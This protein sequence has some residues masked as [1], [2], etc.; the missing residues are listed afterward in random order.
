[1]SSNPSPIE[2][3][4]GPR[5]LELLSAMPA[6]AD[7]T[8][9][10]LLF[11]HGLGH[12][13]WCWEHW[14]RESATRGYAGYAVSLRGHGG[15]AG[16]LRTAR[17]SH[18]VKDVI[19]TAASLPRRP[20]LVGH[21][22]GGLVVQQALARYAAHAGVLVAPVPAHPAVGSLASIA[23]QHPLDAVRMTLGGSLPLRPRYL[24]AGLDPSEAQQQAHRCGPESPFAQYQLL[25]H[26]PPAPPRGRAPVLVLATPN[27]RLVPISDVR[28]TAQRYGATLREFPGMGHDLMLDRDWLSPLETTLDWLPAARG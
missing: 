17:L 8:K 10:P 20:V 3:C 1:M 14:L 21:S 16:T 7:S 25:L 4:T 28:R 11:V 15:S 9:P 12:G 24:F 6:V 26:R 2:R 22:M 19:H 23:R 27:D 18:Y 5:G 13:A